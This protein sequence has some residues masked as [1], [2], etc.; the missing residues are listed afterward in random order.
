MRPPCRVKL[1]RTVSRWSDECLEES[2]SLCGST[3]QCRC[4][5]FGSPGCVVRGCERPGSPLLVE[6]P[7]NV[8]AGPYNGW[9]LQGGVGLFKPLHDHEPL[10]AAQRSWSMSLRLKTEERGATTLLAGVGRP[11]EAFPRYLALM[12]G[13]PAFWSGGS[14]SGHVL[15]GDAVLST[16]MWHSLAVSVDQQGITW[17]YADGVPVAS[18]TVAL[19]AAGDVLEMAPASSP[20]PAGHALTHFGG[21]LAQVSLFSGEL[22]AAQ[23]ESLKSTPA[24]LDN[25][26]FEEGSKPWFVQTRG[27]SGM[28]APQDPSSLPHSAAAPQA[29]VAVEPPNGK[30]EPSED[31][32]SLTLRH[33][34]QMADAATVKDGGSSVSSGSYDSSKWMRATVAGTVLNTL[35]D[36]GVYPHPDT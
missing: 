4:S 26:P 35:I 31:G 11:H 7:T 1:A 20:W 27:P 25:L 28:H 13:R 9:F 2:W 10:A 33:A 24:G 15:E 16:G 3:W 17:L 36:P 6:R 5:L 22:S 29:P 18:G 30:D 12:D 19:G 14:G 23:L 21:H 32:A 8:V 34:W